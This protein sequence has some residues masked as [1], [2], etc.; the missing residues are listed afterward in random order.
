[1]MTCYKVQKEFSERTIELL[2]SIDAE[3]QTNRKM[4][5]RPENAFFSSRL[6]LVNCMNP[7]FCRNPPHH[8]PVVLTEKTQLTSSTS[9]LDMKGEAPRRKGLH[10][11]FSCKEFPAHPRWIAKGQ[12]DKGAKKALSQ[13][14]SYIEL[15]DKTRSDKTELFCLSRVWAVSKSVDPSRGRGRDKTHVREKKQHIA[16]STMGFP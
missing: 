6:D 4:H 3:F 5:S 8:H 11:P 2:S 14:Q 16:P 7:T 12:K 15:H 13:L 10:F 1:M 9:Q